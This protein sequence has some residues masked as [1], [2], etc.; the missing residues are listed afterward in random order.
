M[1]GRVLAF[2][3]NLHGLRA[4]AA[5]GVLLFHWGSIF[6]VHHHLHQL[7]EPYGVFWFFSFF[8]GFGWVGVP[9][10]FVLSGFLLTSQLL[11]K[12]MPL[13]TF[14]LRRLLRIYPGVWFQLLVIAILAH[15]IVGLPEVAWGWGTL[16][17]ALLFINLPPWNIE[18]INGVWWTLPVELSFYFLLPA[19]LWWSKK[20][21]L[22]RVVL[23][24]ALLSTLWRYSLITW[25]DRPSYSGV[26]TLL[27]ALPG[28]LIYFCCGMLIASW[29]NQRSVRLFAFLLFSG[30]ASV[31]GLLAGIIA[32]F[33]EYW[34]GHWLLVLWPVLCAPAVAMIVFAASTSVP[35][36]G[37][38]RSRLLVFLGDISFGLYLWHLP[39]LFAIKAYWPEHSSAL[40][41]SLLAL[42]LCMAITTCMA[43]IS[44]YCVERPFMRWRRN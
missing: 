18:P 32:V 36:L 17:N 15:F 31:L 23:V 1:E 44:Y 2:N 9:L 8:I 10:F 5:L 7:G 16:A 43:S 42:F 11:L 39:V 41:D 22:W 20:I 34:T 29:S 40:M 3:P 37:W 19:L 26:Q 14:W 25:L 30:V 6:P 35:R 4:I 24:A 33:D 21:S 27:D 12:P 38:L 28:S 13:S